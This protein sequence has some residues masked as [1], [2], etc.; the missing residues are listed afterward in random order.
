MRY[1][2]VADVMPVVRFKTIKRMFH[3]SDNESRPADCQDK[4]YKIRPL[5]DAVQEKVRG[6]IPAEKLSIDEQVVPF[7]GKSVLRTYNPKKPKKWGYKIFVLSGVDGLIHNLEIYTGKIEPCP[8]QPDIKAASNIVLRLLSSIP[9]NVWHKIYCDNWF[10]SVA[11]HTTLSK[12]GIACLGTVRSNRLPGCTFPTDKVMRRQGRGTTCLQTTTIDGVELRATKW[13]DNRG[14]VL[15]STYAAVDPTTQIERFDRK[16]RRKLQVTCPT[17]VR[18]YNQH[19]G[20][21]DL[22]DALLALY[23]IPVRSKKWYHRLLFHYLDMLL[24]QS[25]LMYRRDADASGLARKKQ[26]PLLRFKMSV[27]HCLTR[28][29]KCDKG[30]KRGRPSLDDV[31]RAIQAKKSREAVAPL[32]EKTVRTDNTGHWPVFSEKKGR[33]KLPGCKHTPKVMCVKCSTY[34]CFTPTNN[35]FQLFHQ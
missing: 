22:L 29:G 4:L 2:K 16:L 19:M 31:E 9:R 12:Q 18:C 33:C 24:V 25:W 13:F 28:Q 27:A 15:L 35:C 21:V 23:R 8:G 5:V 26:L 3:V 34:L 11:L 6:I 30:A 7:K 20:G 1:P 32:P 10:T 14:V 17:A